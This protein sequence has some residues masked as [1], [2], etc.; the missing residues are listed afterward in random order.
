MTYAQVETKLQALLDKTV[1]RDEQ[2]KNAVLGVAHGEFTWSGAA[3]YADP[4]GRTPMTPETPFFIASITKTYTAAAI[5]M[6]QEQGRLDLADP[7]AK[8]LPGSLIQGLHSYKGTDYVPQIT[9]RHLLCMTAGIAD[10]S[11]EKDKGGKA[12]HERLFTE[13]DRT[14]TKEDV[15]RLVREEL[16][17]Y[18]PP[19][20]PDAATGR[21]LQAKA[22]YS[23]T[24]FLLLG[25][26]IE[27]VT[28]KDLQ[29]V[30]DELLFQPLG[31]TQ[32]YLR[33][34]KSATTEPAT[35]FFHEK[36]LNLDLA[37]QTIAAHGGMVSTVQD[38]LRFLKALSQD[39]LFARKG[40]FAAMQQWNRIF[41]PFQYGVGLMRFKMPRLFSPFFPSP[42]LVGHSGSTG[43]FLYFCPERNLYLAGTLNQTQ[44]QRATFP[45]MLQVA[46]IFR[47]L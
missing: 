30:Y 41:F 15:A 35:L 22:H 47:K 13:G 36:P 10:Y 20:T 17:P 12:F 39:Q 16:K 24:N 34:F 21:H 29:S 14:Y 42:E 31:L 9:I 6:L 2:I 7:I 19:A 26:I 8:H 38:G 45:L 44:R 33:G 40:T 27:A 11:L 32:T 18:F 1:K 28:G 43:S 23:D 3:G 5:L 25:A 4:T 37:M 46:E